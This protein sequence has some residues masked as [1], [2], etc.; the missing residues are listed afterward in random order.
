MTIRDWTFFAWS[1]IRCSY[2][3]GLRP[4]FAATTRIAASIRAAP[5]R[6][7][8]M[9]IS[10][11]GASMKDMCLVRIPSSTM[12]YPFESLDIVVSA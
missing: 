3:W 4:S 6:V 8:A 1:V 10:W 5:E 2:V 12:L 11:P 7:V 9:S